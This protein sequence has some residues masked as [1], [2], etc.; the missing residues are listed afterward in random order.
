VGGAWRDQ[1][2]EAGIPLFEIPRSPIKLWR[3]WRLSCLFRRLRPSIIQTWSPHLAAYAQWT[4][5]KGNARIIFGV[6]E[7]L[8][9]DRA[10]GEPEKK[11]LKLPGLATSD[12]AIGNSQRNF[13][14]LERC[15]VRLPPHEVIRNQVVPRGNAK[16]GETVPTPRMVGIGSLRRLKAYD[17]LLQALGRLAAEGRS[18][19]L[20][21]AGDGQDRQELED[22][23]S[24]L[25]LTDRVQFLGEVDDVWSLLDSAHI[26]VHPSRSEGLCNTI[27][28]GM[29]DG[30][31]IVGTWETASE[32]VENERE[33]LL[34]PAGSPDAL[35]EAIGRL[36]GDPPLRERLGKAALER[37]QREFN[38]DAI[39][40]QYE[41]AYHSL[42]A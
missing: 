22:L 32:I 34:V 6:L 29:A 14:K 13:E 19:E 25:N 41:R 39:T 7:D 27:L 36:L 2:N 5:T 15:G 30:L 21:L 23:S 38:A 35:A 42:L 33:G 18:F 40:Q 17:V 4:W 24:E 1:W 8:T 11:A 16:P 31:P 37:V 3:L 26:L 20:L 12:Y 9:I 28:E 10:T